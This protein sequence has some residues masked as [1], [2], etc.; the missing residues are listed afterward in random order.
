MPCTPD[1][2]TVKKHVRVPLSKHGTIAIHL[3]FEGA[4]HYVLDFTLVECIASI[5]LLGYD[6]IL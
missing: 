4:R 6:K 1:I 5:D 2:F 3:P